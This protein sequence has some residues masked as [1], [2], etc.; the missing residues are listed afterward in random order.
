VLVVLEGPPHP[1]RMP[2]GWRAARESERADIGAHVR[3][4]GEQGQ[5]P[6]CQP[7]DHLDRDKPA[8]QPDRDP[9]R[10]VATSTDRAPECTSE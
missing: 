1:I 7:A 3:R 9:Q 2:F 8:V 5:R 6:E 10:T 4:V